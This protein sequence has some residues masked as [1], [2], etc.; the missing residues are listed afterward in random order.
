MLPTPL[1]AVLAIALAAPDVQKPQQVRIAVT[2][3]N[4]IDL[5]ALVGLLA[6]ATGR[7]VARPPVPVGLPVSG[8][9]GALTRRVLAESLGP[10]VTV[11]LRGQELVITLDPRLLA[12]DRLPD[13]QRRL[14]QLGARADREAR[15]RLGY[16]MH[17]R[18][19]YRPNDP[20]RPTICLVHGMNSSSRGFVHMIEPLEEAGYG[21]VLFDYPF[22]HPLE[23]SCARF[24]RDLRSFRRVHGETRPWA[25]VAHS[26]GALVAR[27]Y[28]EDPAEPAGQVST[29]ILIAPVSQGSSLARAQALRQWLQGLQSVAG[30]APADPL[31]YLGDGAGDAAID[32][33]PGSA[34]LTALN[35]RPRRAGVAYHILAGD[36]GFMPLAARRRI[37]AQV[38]AM[39][40]QGGLLAGLSRVIA[41][42][43]P[44]QLDELCDGTGDG[45]VTIERT[46]LDGVTDHV[47]V[48]ANHAELIR[49]PLLF[50]DPGPV[51]SM[52][53][54]LRWLKASA[55]PAAVA[56]DPRP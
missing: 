35:G 2:A 36:S 19:S 42:D 25:I 48:H 16:G 56:G 40:Q 17:A 28:V 44:A 23:E 15:R 39:R 32:I 1:I 4:E 41:H 24:R 21:V 49:A 18:D 20:G 53:Y 8:P 47:T 34:F 50:P 11:D 12:P 30:K 51:V 31:A 46:R 22:N 13:W 29:L 45:C 52:P 38:Q 3:Q 9:A 26:M 14:D 55:P 43:L 54:I 6:D 5:S 33:L 27:A 37:E 7:T 10:E